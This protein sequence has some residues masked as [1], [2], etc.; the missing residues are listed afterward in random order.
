MIKSNDV[1]IDEEMDA[2]DETWLESVTEGK[3]YPKESSNKNEIFERLSWN[4]PFSSA[5]SHRSKQSVSEIKRQREVAD[6]GSGTEMIR[7]FKKPLMNRPRFMQEK[8]LSP[9]E[10]GTAM[11]MVM[12][13]MRFQNRLIMKQLKICWKKWLR[14]NSLQ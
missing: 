4:Y 10:I 3:S 14:K 6:E 7:K 5:S 1:R 2:I 12:Q 9:A 13:H 11:H 8:A